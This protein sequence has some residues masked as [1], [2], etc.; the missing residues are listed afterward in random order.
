MKVK[1][2]NVGSNNMNWT[3]NLQ[4][5]SFRELERQIKSKGALMSRTL[6]FIFDEESQK[7][8]IIV[9]VFRKVGEFEVVETTS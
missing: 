9:G 5:L 7:G 3:A 8:N 1:F 2:I 4:S 6:D